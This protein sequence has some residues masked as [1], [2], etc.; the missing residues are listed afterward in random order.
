MLQNDSHMYMKIKVHDKTSVYIFTGTYQTSPTLLLL[1][2]YTY[3][4]IEDK[5]GKEEGEQ[6]EKDNYNKAVGSITSH[7]FGG[8][9]EQ[10]H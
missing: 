10:N 6:E 8:R 1:Q 7:F 9:G 2:C 5:H 4:Y 3:M